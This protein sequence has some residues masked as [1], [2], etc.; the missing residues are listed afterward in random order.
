MAIA[1]GM[2]SD[3]MVELL[4]WTGRAEIKVRITIMSCDVMSCVLMDLWSIIQIT[5]FYQQEDI[6]MG[7]DFHASYPDSQ[8][9]YEERE[10][11]AICSTPSIANDES[12]LKRVVQVNLSRIVS[13]ARPRRRYPRPDPSG[14]PPRPCRIPGAASPEF[15]CCHWHGTSP[16][17]IDRCARCRSKLTI[18]K[19]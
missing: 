1:I 15:C 3:D 12:P 16:P 6:S 4:D 8:W 13:L 10:N 5:Q 11:S 2:K 17:S 7:S 9:P 14:P 19:R 18:K